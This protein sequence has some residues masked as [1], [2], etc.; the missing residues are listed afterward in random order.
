MKRAWK[1]AIAAVFLST[2]GFATAELGKAVTAAQGQS[3]EIRATRDGKE[4]GPPYH[5][6][7]LCAAEFLAAG[8]F[9]VLVPEIA[10][11][12]SH[13]VSGDGFRKGGS[14]FIEDFGVVKLQMDGQ[15]ENDRG[16]MS[17][18]K[19]ELIEI[20]Q[21]AAFFGSGNH[22]IR[23]VEIS[24]TE[25]RIV[26]IALRSILKHNVTRGHGAFE[27]QSAEY[28][29]SDLRVPLDMPCPQ[30]KKYWLTYFVAVSADEKRRFLDQYPSGVL[31]QELV[32][33]MTPS[34]VEAI[35]GAPERKAKIGD[36]LIYFYPRMKLT[37]VDD[38]LVDIQ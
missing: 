31:V 15:I 35:L 36:K 33:G 14:Y 27:H 7:T 10:A 2:A 16:F 30:F 12:P 11:S 13:G 8:V 21:P 28:L 17:F 9:E 4:I 26:N 38:K 34:E 1:W 29:N 22:P 37:F 6:L 5:D 20:K 3:L 19:G 25:T 32:E 18:F 24:R 23:Q